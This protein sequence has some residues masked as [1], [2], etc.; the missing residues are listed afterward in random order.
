MLL[1][2][3][4][5][6]KNSIYWMQ[7]LNIYGLSLWIFEV[8]IVLNEIDINIVE[9]LENVF[10]IPVHFPFQIWIEM[11][12]CLHTNNNQCWHDGSIGI[13]LQML[14][15]VHVSAASFLTQLPA[16]GPGK[17]CRKPQVLGPL[18]SLSRPGRV[19]V[20]WLCFGHLGSESLDERVF[21]LTL[22]LS[23]TLPLH[24]R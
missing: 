6:T 20:S 14:V 16:N 17:Q 13:S 21:S 19:T 15:L 12:S 23:I 1:L 10:R 7:L 2:I 22:L 18:H 3:L 5:S 24:D 9:W 4:N 8:S 11:P